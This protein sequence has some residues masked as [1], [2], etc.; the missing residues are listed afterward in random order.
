MSLACHWSTWVGVP[1]RVRVCLFVYV[2]V[3][4]CLLPSWCDTLK[5]ARVCVA[6]VLN[7]RS[8]RNYRFSNQCSYRRRTIED[9]PTLHFLNRHD[10]RA[11]EMF[12]PSMSC[13]EVG[14]LIT[15]RA[16]GQS[17]ARL[18]RRGLHVP[19]MFVL[20]LVFCGIYSVES[21]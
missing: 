9:P 16:R 6:L 1:V 7:R 20:V 11:L 4:V 5:G 3:W 10:S 14:S 2:S 18:R 12:S 8:S 13:F 19:K 15:T 17:F 21:K